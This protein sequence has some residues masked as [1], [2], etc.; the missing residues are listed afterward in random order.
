VRANTATRRSTSSPCGERVLCRQ[1]LGTC[2]CRSPA[3]YLT[4]ATHLHWGISSAGDFA[5][6]RLYRGASTAS[7]PQGNSSRHQDTATSIPGRRQHTTALG[8]GPQRQ[9]E[10]VRPVGPPD[11]DVGEAPR[12]ALALE[13]ARPSPSTA[14]GWSSISRW[15]ATHPGEAGAVDVAGRRLREREVG[16]L[17]ADPHQ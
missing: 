9:R 17:G 10:S 2:A 3:A 15:P 1:P 4:G 16:S 8:G 5:G 13:G 12:Y 11:G 14:G 6:F 7:C